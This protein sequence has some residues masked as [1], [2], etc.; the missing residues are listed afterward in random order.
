MIYLPYKDQPQ[1]VMFLAARTRVPP[2]TLTSAFRKEVQRLDPDLPVYD[3]DTLETRVARNR[4]EVGAMGAVFSAFAFIAMVLAFVG[5]YAVAAHAVS[6]RTREIGIRRALGG[7]DAHVLRLV[8]GQGLGQVAIG[9]AIGL[10]AAF[11]VARILRAVLVDVAPGDPATLAGVV[12]LLM[13]AAFLGCLVP[14]RR[15][16]RV[17][18]VRGLTARVIFTLYRC[19]LTV[20]YSPS[21]YAKGFAAAKS[22]AASESG[23][24]HMSK[25]AAATAWMKARS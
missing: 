23:P 1:P 11:A 24:V 16:I 13:S 17:D 25:W 15:A 2:A 5:L 6:Q 12:L 14:A 3:I 20:W 22:P 9:L 4:F 10:P 21:V 18:P 19:K 8:F 7:S